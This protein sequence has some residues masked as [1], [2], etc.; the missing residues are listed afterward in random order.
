[1][2]NPTP[3]SGDIKFFNK[4]QKK[5]ADTNVAEVVSNWW[6]QIRS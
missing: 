1:M 3:A 6:R 2:P 5:E 4:W